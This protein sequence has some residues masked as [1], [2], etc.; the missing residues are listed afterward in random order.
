MLYVMQEKKTAW[1]WRA[2]C[3]GINCQPQSVYDDFIN[4]KLFHRWGDGGVMFYHYGAELQRRGG[5]STAVLTKARGG[6][7]NTSTAARCWSAP[8]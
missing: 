1:E 4:T 2:A 8:I 7:R 6:W 3:H 5:R